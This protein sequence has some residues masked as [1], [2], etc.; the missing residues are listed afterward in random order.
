MARSWRNVVTVNVLVLAALCVGVLNNVLIAALFGLTRRVDAYFAALMLPNLVMWLCIDYLGKN[1]LPMLALAK[2]ESD[3]SASRL[4]STIVTIVTLFSIGITALLMLFSEPLFS[5]L[6]PGFSGEDAVVV[7]HYFW[8]MA[9]AIVL[10]AITTFHEYVVQ[11]EENLFKIAA[12][13]T[14]L[15]VA[16][17]AGVL[18]LAPWIGEYCL[19]VAYLVGHAVVFVLI[20]MHAPYRYRPRIEIRAHLERR[21][22]A[23]SAVVMST[24]LLARTKN[25]L[26][27]YLASSL[28]SGAISA[29]AF[30]GKITEP[31]Q[32]SAFTGIRMF[33]FSRTARLYADDNR[34]ALARLYSTGLRVSF[35]VMTPLLAWI[36]FNSTQIVELLFGHG[37]FTPE[38]T[39]VVGATLAAL[40]PVVLFVGVNAIISNAFY[41][42]DAVKVPAVIMPFGTLI[43]AALAI[44]LSKVLGTQG[45]ALASTTTTM[46]LFCAL[47]ICLGRRLPELGLSRTALS[48]FGYLALGSALMTV[49]VAALGALDMPA[50]AVAALSLP[51]GGL[52]YL[53]ALLAAR[54]DTLQRLTVILRTWRQPRD[55]AA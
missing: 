44:P 2:K 14:A 20:T 37:K 31:L 27:N 26:M 18:F 41:A 30:A 45:I 17:L 51:L 21:I 42:M 39:A 36:V 47:M 28:G 12:I 54:D 46:T 48:L 22:F 43:Y 24:G 11:Y 29:L 13:R 25:I 23:N 35:M 1:F 32:R 52:F 16:N 49:T 55:A 6:L 4:T 3:D 40:V 15:P 38:A 10:M 19:P 50:A 5:L 8:I 33:M 7:N 9:P 34:R 53:A